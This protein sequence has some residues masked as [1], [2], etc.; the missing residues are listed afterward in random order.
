MIHYTSFSLPLIIWHPVIDNHERRLICH[1]FKAL[2]A[3]KSRKPLVLHSLIFVGHLK[4]E[5]LS[6]I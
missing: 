3:A 4:P 2:D 1:A 6:L 5:F